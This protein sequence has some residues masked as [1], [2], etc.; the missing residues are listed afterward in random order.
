MAVS[1]TITRTTNLFHD[2]DETGVVDPGDTLRTWIVVT[3]ASASPADLATG[4]SIADSLSGSTLV[5]GTLNISPIAFN[6]SFTAVGNTVL[7]VGGAGNIGAGPSSVVAGNLLAN[8]VGSG[9]S[10]IAGDDAPG[11]SIVTVSNGVSAGGG[12][13]NIFSDGSFNYVNEAGDTGTDSFTYTIRDNGLD[14]IANNADDLTST[15]TVTIT[16]SGE[17]WYVDTAAASGGTGTSNNP[18]NTLAAIG[19]AGDPDGNGDVIYLK[20]SATGTIALE[21]DQQLVGTGA[22]L[23]VGGFNLAAAS[24]NATITASGGTVVTLATGNSV[25]GVNVVTGDASTVGIQDGGGTV[26]ALK[27][28][29][30]TITGSGKAIDID[31][32]GALDVDINLLHASGASEG[33]HLAGT[34]ANL[35]T[36]SFRAANGVIQTA[37][38]QGFLIGAAGGGAASSGGSANIFYGGSI[39]SN[40][41]ALVEIQDRTG[42]TVT[43]TGVFTDG[44]GPGIIADG[45]AGAISFN[46]RIFVE[47]G[48]STAVSLTNNSGTIAFSGAGAG[49]DLTTTTGT[50]FSAVNSG[51]VV[52]Q[53]SGNTITSSGGTALNVSSTTIGTGGLTFESISA[54]GGA[55]G[56]VLN[57]TGNTAGLTI[58]GTGTTD[59]SGGTI[60]NTDAR[61]IELIGT[62]NVNI[63]NLNLTNANDANDTVGNDLTLTSAN[64]AVYM[65]NV[66]GA[67]FDNINIT[68]TILDNGITGINVSNFQLNNS[69]INNAGNGANESGIEF[70]NLSGTS[71]L[72][73]SE[74]ALS[75]TNSLDI[76]N[77]DVNLN[78]T[79]NNVVFRDTQSS[80]IGEGGLQFRSFSNAAGAPV[81]N[82]DILDSD[83]LRLRTQAIQVIGEDDSTVSVD[84]VNNVIDS[85]TEI[86]TGIDINGND[87]A[88]VAFNINSNP[89][90]RSSGGSAVNIT[91][92]LNATVM[93]RINN[94]A[95]IET[96]SQNPGITGAYGSGIRVLAQ[97]NSRA[98][99][100]A[101]GNTLTQGLGNNSSAVDAIA[102]EGSARL[103]LTLA[104]NSIIAADPSMLA[105][106]NLQ[107]GSSSSSNIE[108]NQI[109]ANIINNNLNVPGG[110]NL[111]RLR[112][113]ELDDSHNPRI[114][115]QGFV[116][117]GAG[118]E[119][120]TVATWNLNGNTPLGTTGNI[121]VSLSG[122]AT[123]PSAGTAQTP[124]NPLPIFA[125]VAPP[126]ESNAAP[127]PQTGDDGDP[128]TSGNAPAPVAPAPGPAVV[129]DGNLTP[130]ELALIVDAAIARWAAAGA[131]DAQLAAMRGVAVSIDTLAGLQLAESGGGTIRIDDN[132]AGF[133]WFVDAT[134]GDDAEYQA[135]GGRLSAVDA[136]AAAGTRIDLL[137]V[138]MHELGHQIGLGDEYG[139]GDRAD[140]M[141]GTIN[142]GE[143]RLPGSEEVQSANGNA[144]VGAFALA[145]INIGNLPAGQSVTIEFRHIVNASGED[146]LV[147]GVSGSATVDSDQTAPQSSATNVTAVD[148]L[149]LGGQIFIDL[150]KDG[151]LD[152]GEAGPSGVTLTLY[153]DSNN[154]G[155]FSAGDL[156]VG[157][158]ELGGGAGYQQGIDTPAPGG[159]GTALTTATLANGFYSFANLAPGDYIV[160]IGAGN[161]SGGGALN[162]RVVSASAN[163]PDDNVDNDN[164][165]QP[166][167]GL[168]AT[169]AITLAYG[170]ETLAGPTGPALDTNTTLDVGFEIPNQPPVI[171]NL[172]GDSVDFIEGGITVGFDASLDAT[173]AD[174]DSP[175]FAGGSLTVTVIDPLD[176]DAIVIRTGGAVSATMDAGNAS[177]TVSVGGVQIATWTLA[178]TGL[179]M[180]FSFDADATPSAVQELVRALGYRNT[181]Q[182]DPGIATRNVS[183]TLVDGDGRTNGGDDDTNVTTTV[184][185]SA[186]NDAPSGQDDSATI[187]EDSTHVFSAADFNFSD[188]DGNGFAGVMFTTLPANGVIRINGVAISAGGFASAADISSGLVTYTPNDDQVGT[189][190]DTFTFRVRDNGGTAN[191]GADTDQTPNTFTFNV[192]PLND[193]P[194]IS[195]LNGDTAGYTEN[196]APLLLDVGSN[197]VVTDVD[198]FNF[199]LGTL[200]ITINAVGDDAL[201]LAPGTVAV[202]SGTLAVSVAGVEIGTLF[203]VASPPNFGFFIALNANATSERVHEVIRAV[204]YSNT[205]DDPAAGSRTVT[206]TLADGDGS[207]PGET[208][209]IILQNSFAVLAVNDAPVGFDK[210]IEVSEDD[211]YAFFLTDFGFGD[212]EGHDWAEVIISTLPGNGELLLNGVAVTAGQAVS[213]ADINAG[214]LSF[215]PG[216]DETGDN[217]ASFTFQVRDDGGTT[218]G[219]V[220]LDSTPNTITIDVN[221]DNLPPALDLNGAP[222]GIDNSGSYSEGGGALV[223]APAALITDADDTDIESARVTITGGLIAGQDRLTVN[224]AITGTVNGITIAYNATTGVLTLTGTATLATYQAVLRQVGFDSISEAPGT[225][226]TLSWT[227]NDGVDDSPAATTT[228]AV[229]SINDLPAGASSTIVINEDAA[230]TLSAADFGFSDVDGSFASVTIGSVSGG[231]IFFDAD[232]VGPALATDVM[233]PRVFTAAELAGGWVSFVP[234]SNANGAGLG[235]ISFAV[236]DDDGGSDASPNTLTIDVTAVNDAPTLS[237]A[238]PVSATEQ[239]AIAVLSG[240]TVADVDLDQKNGGLGDYAGA[241]F[242]LNR[243]PGADA[244]DV[245]SLVAGSGFTI[246]GNQLK[247]GGLVFG[248]FSI[249]P[250]GFIQISFTSSQTI[251]TSALADQVIQSV[252]YLNASD[253]PPLSIDLAYGFTDGSPGQGQGNGA[254]NLDVKLVTVGITAVNDAPINSL[255]P[256]QAGTEDVNLVFSTANG[257]AITVSDAEASTLQ[258]S[259]SVANGL[260]TL[261][262][263]AG[264]SFSVGDGTGD[265]TMTF[266]GTAAAINA[267]LDGLV[268]R[269]AL[270]YHGVD[271]LTVTTSDL[272]VAGTGG[273][274]TDQ[275][276]I[277]ISLAT[278]G[279]VDGGAGDDTTTGTSGA[280]QFL[281]QQG[282]HDHGD[283]GPG[284]AND[285][286]YFGDQWES[287]DSVDGGGGEDALQLAG[288]YAYAFG[289]T[290]MIS[291]ER[292]RLGSGGGADFDYYLT[293]ADGNVA[294]GEQLLVDATSLVAGETLTFLGM[295]EANGRYR[296]LGGAG[297][298]LLVAGRQN[299]VVDGGAGNDTLYGGLGDDRISGGLGRDILNGGSGGDTVVYASAAESTGLGF[300][301]IEKFSTFVD[302]IDLPFAVTGWSG[303]VSTGGLSTASFDGDLAAAV[304][305]SLNGHSAVLFTASSGDSAGRTFAVIDGNGDGSY[306]AGQDYVIEFAQPVA[307]LDAT[308]V[309][310][311]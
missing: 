264:L 230:R 178:G 90:I 60:Q 39:S 188:V 167:S 283:G 247:A 38:N 79:L 20:G 14:G 226:R 56:I 143:R 207:G 198:S 86:G 300:D 35:L 238:A 286:F 21:T 158:N 94:N 307:S 259:L 71:S 108:T 251:A 216:P 145:P 99:V 187:A 258:V 241:T 61:G 77:T 98:I 147:A 174:S 25:L 67:V 112:V 16:L 239:T 81:T 204:Q 111:L 190:L 155:V 257:N 55:K 193:A 222:A 151:I 252:R 100:Q 123:G 197:A 278:D 11:F 163:D 290:Q 50:G 227:V 205:G 214:L 70:N 139:M 263:L 179:S 110:P 149:T 289:E 53:G 277:T 17:V 304:N 31:Q 88:N 235:S 26:G 124:S 106:I 128:E 66:S 296:I 255:T 138:V 192:T 273:T 268:Y 10:A 121:A 73:N 243:N 281:F 180:V 162:G 298:D 306:Q 262:G 109:Y 229:T 176:D 49:M 250:T 93:G 42:G 76:V 282:G 24:S 7:R 40:G 140:L 245:F 68:G 152:P 87:N 199:E 159:T 92:F 72:T 84:I 269:G 185:L 191:G 9:P 47:S 160:V 279:F 44:S 154:D 303:T 57:N 144:V 52:I 209:T 127:A 274:R 122:T 231:R 130:A 165:G 136:L 28:D 5:P 302:R 219:G 133:S 137:T 114:F 54:N 134:P 183:F 261:S 275:D 168:V 120:D 113:S 82:I 91:S 104:G 85:G 218:D 288:D 80:G 150:D 233:L 51:T 301:T 48:A 181:N 19:G 203:P 254:T 142:P 256:T 253:T 58:T 22:A 103:D 119:D 294:A 153:A 125:A 244:Q 232:G 129:D 211:P 310:F 291:I 3:N 83:F 102:R 135:A 23:T 311:V 172:Q 131:T 299:D 95:D 126:V 242:S 13:F 308:S 208:S 62:A 75:E 97:E 276:V 217:Y 43:F 184:T 6:D 228:I 157:Y 36:G 189:A 186:V 293:M 34:A 266:S 196:G 236:T 270:N 221:P 309:Y 170:T 169:R 215:V 287:G 213:R 1:F 284:N 32:G 64:G 107:S 212:A 45:N 272:G 161:F 265:S 4:V 101:S 297:D 74:I 69:V 37:T 206:Y 292:L 295:A 89:T 194:L 117:A 27:I 141:F 33:V 280:D 116:E 148:G 96:Y 182:I 166:L 224:G 195:N 63:K 220:D 260:L 285:R 59:G 65:S 173:I 15:A 234:T 164:N 171:G 12:T 146:G 200:T 118:I 115:L 305:A 237:A 210:T 249:S 156:Y 8:D 177:G 225:S 223:L 271:S 267:A 132:G 202:D 18:F 105:A 240:V 201:S 248:T 2:Q 29:A 246:D 41:L 46:N 175:D 30:I 78:L